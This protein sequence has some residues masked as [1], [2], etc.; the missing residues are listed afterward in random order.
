LTALDKNISDEEMDRLLVDRGDEIEALL[1]EARDA[2]ARGEFA[3]LEP[4]D[5][6]LRRAR[7]RYEA[8]H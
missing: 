2:R 3:P 8:T 4:L 6:F 1:A 7:E 5:A